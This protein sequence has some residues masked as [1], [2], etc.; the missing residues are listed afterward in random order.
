MCTKFLSNFFL[1]L[2][3]VGPLFGAEMPTRKHIPLAEIYKDKF[4]IGSTL[5]GGMEPEGHPFRQDRKELQILISE[6]NCITAENSMKMQYMQPKEGQFNFRSSDALVALAEASNMEIVGHALVWHHQVPNWIFKDDKGEEISREILIERM[7]N[8]IY[9]IMQRYKGRVKYWDVVNEAVDVKN[10][11]GKRVAHF[12]ESKW[13]KIIGEEYLELAYKFAQEADPNALL[14]YNDYSMTEVS[15]TKFVADM[16]SGLKDKGINIHGIGMQSHWHLD[17]PHTSEIERAI[18]TLASTGCKIS[19]TELDIGVIPR[20][21][22][23]ADLNQSIEL[24][25]ELDPYRKSIP[26][27][28][29]SEQANRY[30]SIFKT[31]L[32]HSEKIERVTFWGTLDHYSWLKNWPIQGRTAYPNLFDKNY[33][34]KPAYFSIRKLLK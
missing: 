11:G 25:K 12:R 22:G 21:G 17:F 2:F 20:R 18:K 5:S 26:K 31:F 3:L 6:F 7:R 30:A 23:G 14:L 1:A 8:H 33:K 27:S 4:L 15:K 34:A 10:V 13:F 29:L 16:V 24:R 32:K 28:V 19:I 9:T